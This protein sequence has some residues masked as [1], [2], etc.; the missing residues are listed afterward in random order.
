MFENGWSEGCMTES[1]C[2]KKIVSSLLTYLEL[3]NK[4]Q[5]SINLCYISVKISI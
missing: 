2:D 4:A 1:K 3:K 5:V